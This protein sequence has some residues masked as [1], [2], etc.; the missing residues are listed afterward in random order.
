MEMVVA[1]IV[2]AVAGLGTLAGIFM[3]TRAIET[4]WLRSLL[5]C[6]ATVWLLVPWRI[7]AVDGYYAPAY[8]VA[9]FEGVFR[10][11]GNPRPALIVL[12]LA[13]LV[14]IVILLIA[15]AIRWVRAPKSS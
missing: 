8:I 11:D 10:A 12:A 9:L 1:W 2:V 7:E 3:L 14:V 6:L 13:S 5:R 15:G 4:Q